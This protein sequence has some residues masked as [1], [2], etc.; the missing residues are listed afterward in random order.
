MS[1]DYDL[2]SELPQLNNSAAAIA[3]GMRIGELESFKIHEILGVPHTLVPRGMVL[4]NMGELADR[5]AIMAFNR[6]FD[7]PASFCEFATSMKLAETGRLYGNVTDQSIWGIFS[8]VNVGASSWEKQKAA[9]ALKPSPEWGKWQD[10]QRKP[11]SQVDFVEFLEEMI[12]TIVEPDGTT[13]TAAYKTFQAMQNVRV[14]QVI[15]DGGDLQ[16]AVEE[17]VRGTVREDFASIPSKLLLS[18][19][20]FTMGKRYAVEGIINYRLREGAVTF[21]IKLLQL[22]EIVETAFMEVVEAVQLSLGMK[23][24]F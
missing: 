23:V 14:K 8:D 18:L 22:D 15:R 9:L 6:T 4:K 13:I 19:R 11:L 10:I 24:L 16:V 12:H 7:E 17:E 20:P 3:A 2:R 21:H 5:P 1:E